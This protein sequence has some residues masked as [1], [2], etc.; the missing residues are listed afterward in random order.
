MTTTSGE[1]NVVVFLASFVCLCSLF[2][3]VGYG[4]VASDLPIFYESTAL[5]INVNL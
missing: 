1:Q 3:S 5:E 4:L 2:S